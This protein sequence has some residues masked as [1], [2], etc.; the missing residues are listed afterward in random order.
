MGESTH[1]RPLAL[2]LRAQFDRTGELADIDQ[3]ISA[4]K[5]ET[6]Y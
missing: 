4:L 1:L 5:P 3:V 6:G 2:A